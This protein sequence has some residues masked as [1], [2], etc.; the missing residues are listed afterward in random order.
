MLD[1]GVQ[2]SVQLNAKRV[3]V[4]PEQNRPSTY[5]EVAMTSTQH[6]KSSLEVEVENQRPDRSIFKT[7]KPQGAFRDK[8]VVEINTIDGIEFRGTI[9]TKEAIRTI[10]MEALGFGKEDLGSLTIG[11]SKGRIITYKLLDQFDIDSLSSLE[12]FEFKRESRLRNGEM[13]EAVMGCRIRGTRSRALPSSSSL[14]YADEGY[15]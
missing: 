11:Y 13:V 4:T 10:F 7:P 2:R 3:G 14:P 1:I 9:T 15:R 6:N 12:F 5:A 8:I